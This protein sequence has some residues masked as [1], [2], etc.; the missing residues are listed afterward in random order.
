[1]VVAVSWDKGARKHPVSKETVINDVEAL[2]LVAKMVLAF[3]WLLVVLTFC[4]LR[5]G[6]RLVG[7]A[8][9]NIGGFGVTCCCPAAMAG[10]AVKP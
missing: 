4:C 9:I 3:A 2:G 10:P 1:M 5:L 7:T 6:S 8:V